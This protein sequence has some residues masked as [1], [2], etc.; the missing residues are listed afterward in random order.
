MLRLTIVSVG[1]EVACI[2]PEDGAS[3]LLLN[4]RQEWLERRE[5]WRA[6]SERAKLER[7][8]LADP[9]Q[10]RR[11][12]NRRNAR[13]FRERNREHYLNYRRAYLAANRERI[14]AYKRALYAKGKAA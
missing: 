5:K 9:A 11:A 3:L 7:R 4:V 10:R 1:P 6:Q 14:N 12:K 8:M 2:C 13:R